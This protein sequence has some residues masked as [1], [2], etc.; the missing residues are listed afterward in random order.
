MMK[1][2]DVESGKNEPDSLVGFGGGGGGD[3]DT[4]K[5]PLLIVEEPDKEEAAKKGGM[6]MSE[7]KDASF[8]L[9]MLFIASVL[10]TVGNKVRN[11]HISSPPS[12]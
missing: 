12:T 1:S 6:P 3:M 7:L 9:F 10:M 2:S 8:W 4:T 5:E 11:I